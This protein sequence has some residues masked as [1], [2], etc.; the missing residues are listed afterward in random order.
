MSAPGVSVSQHTSPFL[1]SAVHLVGPGIQYSSIPST[2]Q[3][4]SSGS[5]SQS[6]GPAATSHISSS[7]SIH[8]DSLSSHLEKVATIKGGSSLQSRE[9]ELSRERV[10]YGDTT[11][12]HEEKTSL[13]SAG[14]YSA[15]S[16]IPKVSFDSVVKEYGGGSDSPT[17]RSDIYF[18]ASL[19]GKEGSLK[20]RIL[21]RPSESELIDDHIKVS[22]VHGLKGEPLSKRLKTTHV[23]ESAALAYSTKVSQGHH[24]ESQRSSSHYQPV[25]H[26][27]HY[28][29]PDNSIVLE[30]RGVDARHANEV[31]QPSFYQ[32]GHGEDNGSDIIYHQARYYSS[33][34]SA[35]SPISPS[36]DSA[37]SHIQYPTHF[38]KGSIIQLANGILKRVEDLQ[39]EDF[40]NSAEISS[41][42]KVDSST[43]VRIEEQPDRGTAMLSFSVG[44]HRVQV[45]THV[46]T[47]RTS[48]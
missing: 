9:G 34:A 14:N 1:Q 45:S 11:N 12:L 2:S 24:N 41:D 13:C 3:H 21:T 42:L 37:P 32:H 36:T 22:G 26:T 27:S 10:I 17:G 33:P 7:S 44:E 23:G 29:Q 5:S 38:I 31:Q 28:S 19:S 30:G 43:V 20:H 16:H 40:V 35:A 46:S 8:F 25:S 47:S 39:T 6:P 48:M 4:L 15:G 18:R